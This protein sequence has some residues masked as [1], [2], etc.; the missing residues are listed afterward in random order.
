MNIVQYNPMLSGHVSI[1]INNRENNDIRT[2]Q[3]ERI[4]LNTMPLCFYSVYIS[5]KITN[6]IFHIIMVVLL[7][8]INYIIINSSEN[9]V[10]IILNIMNYCGI[11]VEC[12]NLIDDIFNNKNKMLL[13]FDIVKSI[14]K[15]NMVVMLRMIYPITWSV[16]I[17][18][19]MTTNG[20]NNFIQN[21]ILIASYTYL[22]WYPCYQFIMFPCRMIVLLEY[23]LS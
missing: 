4:N 7:F 13:Q 16:M 1:Q 17:Y 14:T 5:L 9:L 19:H 12:I 2:N 15:F 11:S 10:I 18:L 8:D 6:I 21:N 20:F 22:F 3:N 23:C